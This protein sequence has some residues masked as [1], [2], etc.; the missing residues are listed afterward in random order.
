ML[1][2]RLLENKTKQKNRRKWEDLAMLGTDLYKEQ[3]V[4]A[5][6]RPRTRWGLPAPHF[7]PLSGSGGICGQ[8]LD[9]ISVLNP[10]CLEEL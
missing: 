2:F 9:E 5:E 7:F 4:A 6:Y 8:C 10:E 1:D 3:Q